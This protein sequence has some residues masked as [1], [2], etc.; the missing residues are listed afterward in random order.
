VDGLTWYFDADGA[1][2]RNEVLQQQTGGE[3]LRT[4]AIVAFSDASI[5]PDTVNDAQLAVR[6]AAFLTARLGL[7]RLA[8]GRLSGRSDMSEYRRPDAHTRNS[9][10]YSD[11]QARLA[12]PPRPPVRRR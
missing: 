3:G 9:G 10:T 8:L 2:T 5:H 12:Q 6:I 7:D 11:Q 1:T 4:P